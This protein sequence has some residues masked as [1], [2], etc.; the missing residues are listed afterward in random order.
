MGARSAA[1]PPST[2]PTEVASVPPSPSRPKLE[3]CLMRVCPLADSPDLPPRLLDGGRGR[4]LSI[5]SV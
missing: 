5:A 3:E 1:L 2:G 4:L